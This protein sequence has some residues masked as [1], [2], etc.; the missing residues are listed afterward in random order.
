MVAC[1]GWLCGL[2]CWLSRS[3]RAHERGRDGMQQVPGCCCVSGSNEAAG[4]AQQCLRVARGLLPPA[5]PP[6]PAPGLAEPPGTAPCAVLPGCHP[7]SLPGDRHR[8]PSSGSWPL[9]KDLEDILGTRRA[10]AL[11]CRCATVWPRARVGAPAAARLAQEH[12]RAWA[13][14]PGAGVLYNPSCSNNPCPEPL[15]SAAESCSVP[16]ALGLLRAGC[17]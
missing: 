11:F 1:A 2:V 6:P 17:W 14:L 9:T 5:L 16:R 8:D 3:S 13:E 4:A 12:P 15:C 10:G 7:C